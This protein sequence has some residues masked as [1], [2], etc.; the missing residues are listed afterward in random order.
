MS[1]NDEVTGSAENEEFPT[2]KIRMVSPMPG[3]EIH[4]DFNL[5]AVDETGVLWTLKSVMDPNVRLF[6]VPPI[7]FFDGYTP[8]IPSSARERVGLKEGEDPFILVIV[9]PATGSY[10][11]TANLLAPLVINPETMNALQVVLEDQ[12]WPLQAPIGDPKES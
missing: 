5:S 2:L 9:H 3:L 12:D 7:A 6:A 10:P 8:M 1:N 11:H 4:L